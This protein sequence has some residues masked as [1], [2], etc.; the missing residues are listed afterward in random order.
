[1]TKETK[2]LEEEVLLLYKYK[3]TLVHSE[4]DIHSLLYLDAISEIIDVIDDVIS[5]L[6]GNL[7]D[8][9]FEEE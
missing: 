9:I 6:E 4:E 8:L 7:E 1:M 5:A 3:D 2:Q